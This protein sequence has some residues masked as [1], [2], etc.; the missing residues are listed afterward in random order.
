MEDGLDKCNYE[1][2]IDTIS[3]MGFECA[4][5]ACWPQGKA[6]RRYAGVSHIDVVRV[7]KDD[8]YAKHVLDYA[9]DHNITISS[10]AFYPNTM[11]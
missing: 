2:M 11:D 3:G 4:E 8:K 9:K 6:E 1:E 7:L 5:V 10:L